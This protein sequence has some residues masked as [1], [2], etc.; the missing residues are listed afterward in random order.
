M[1]AKEAKF[2]LYVKLNL[3]TLKMILVKGSMGNICVGVL[4]MSI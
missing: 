4:K 3:K 2:L 1:R